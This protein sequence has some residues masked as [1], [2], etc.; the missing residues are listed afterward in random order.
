MDTRIL[1]LFVVGL[2]LLAGC[3]GPLQTGAASESS[4]PTIATSG[5]GEVTAEADLAVVSLSV[6]SE[7]DTAA[8]ARDDNAARVE[9]LR[10]A[11]ADAGF[12]DALQST[13]FT[14]RVDRDREGDP[15]GFVA[16]HSFEVEVAPADAGTVVDVAVDAAGTEV[17]NVRFTLTDESRAELRDQAL[18]LAVE[19]ARADADT[20]AAAADLEVTG[21]L[22]AT[23]AG[24]AVPFREV[25]F[26]ERAGGAATSFS[27]G[28]V[29]VAA[30][31]QL[32]Y[33][34]A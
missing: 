28:P 1:P 12:A 17:S 13:G 16:T 22:T 2:V 14:L 32:T 11:M 4:G 23:T 5:T 15:E 9:S 8:A 20:V 3:A 33:T 25:A 7:A 30:T 18:T 21:V 19:D 34:A 29:T 26:D 27:P 6:V 24:D 31:V 10:G